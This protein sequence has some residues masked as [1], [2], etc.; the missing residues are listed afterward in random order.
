MN[1]EKVIFAFFVL[2][3]ATLNIGFIYGGV[4]D[5]GHHQLW[6]LFAATVVSLIAAVLKFGDRSHLGALQLASSMVVLLQ[7][8]GA[9]LVWF[10][11]NQAVTGQQAVGGLSTIVSLSVGALFANLVSV[12]IMLI[13]TALQRR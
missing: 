11:A 9:S 8:V 3:A 7:L 1:L 13:D 4:T 12:V 2:L 10:F 6:Q 5:A